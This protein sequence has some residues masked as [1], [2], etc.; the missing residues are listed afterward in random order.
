MLIAHGANIHEINPEVGRYPMV[1]STALSDYR[2]LEKLLKLGLDPL[3]LFECP[4][5]DGEDYP[6]L[7]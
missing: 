5:G 7:S 4:F 3:T 1:A 6:N 2:F